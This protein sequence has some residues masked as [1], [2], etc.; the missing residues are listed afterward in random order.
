MK[1]LISLFAFVGIM[2]FPAAARIA[3][4][5][6]GPVL[7]GPGETILGDTPDQNG[8]IAVICVLFGYAFF[9]LLLAAIGFVLYAA[10][11]YLTSAGDPAKITTANKTLIFAAVAIAL[12]ARAVPVIVGSFVLENS[13]QSAFDVCSST[14][15]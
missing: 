2:A 15:N 4:A 7:P 13:S 1:K 3:H 5:I 10:F 14:G 9:A 11:N 12:L 8:V 6:S